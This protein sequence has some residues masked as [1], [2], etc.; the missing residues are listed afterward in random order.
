MKQFNHK[1]ISQPTL[2]IKPLFLSVCVILGSVSVSQAAITNINGAGV[3]NQNNG[4]TIVH[5]KGASDK[6]VSHNIYSQFDVDQ[7][8]VIL[9]NSATNTNT[10]LGGQ[11][12]GNLNL[13]NGNGP[14]KVILN[15]VNSTNASTLNGMVEVAGQKAQVIVAN[16]SGITCNNCGFINT[17][18][19]TLTTGKPIVAGGEV[20]GYNVEKGQ[21]IINSRLQ[22]DSPTDIIARSAVIRG[23]INA[24]EI[25]IVAGNNFVDA[26][27]NYVTNVQGVGSTARVGIDVSALGGMYADKITLVSTESGTGVSNYGSMVAGS[28]GINI[29]SKG[30]VYNQNAKMNANGKINIKTNSGLYNNSTIASNNDIDINTNNGILS[31]VNGQIKSNGGSVT[32]TTGSNIDN[33]SGIVD[34]QQNINLVSTNLY[35][36]NGSI[37][38]NRGDIDIRS[39]GTIENYYNLRNNVINT[40]NRGIRSGNNVTINAGKVVNS[41]STISGRDIAINARTLIANENSS[42]IVAKRRIDIDAETLQN[43]N[44]LIKTTNG[45]T[46]ITLSHNLVNNGYAAIDSGKALNITANILQNQGSLVSNS[47]KSKFNV[48]SLINQ[49]GYIKGTN[50]DIKATNV[51]NNRGLITADNDVVINT[52][53]LDNSY[54]S[55]FNAY[56]S[57]FGVSGRT[58]GI[59][60]ED[61]AVNINANSLN[62][63]SGIIAADA[64]Q[65]AGVKGD[66]NIK[67]RNDLDNR[68]G[69]IQGANTVKLDVNKLNNTYSG[70]VDAGKD[71]IIDA[72]TRVDN[73]NGRLSSM[74]TTKITSPVIYNSPYGKILGSMI[75]LNTP[76]YY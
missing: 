19:V 74:G 66:I 29:D 24:K 54:A 3:I 52:T 37:K 17:D 60:A 38:T 53:S 58:G 21:I 43:S 15:E 42:E 72:F 55:G 4:P 10:T 40:D 34:A 26:K 68:Y 51:T 23:D 67:L 57:K 46:N 6:G 16:A 75:I 63:Y 2:K 20:L 65:K 13:N 35:N 28:G 25:N 47:G 11:I 70:L 62:N 9:N 56:A 31:N 48:Y 5:I 7:K 73:N 49:Y 64:S 44:S 50:L 18:R 69:K 59:Y 61:G 36:T 71:L 45:Q 33:R 41:N 14:A 12:N 76:N 22:S 27:G 1:S 8:G 30:L 39:T 32:L